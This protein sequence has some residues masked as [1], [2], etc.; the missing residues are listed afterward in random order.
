MNLKKLIIS[1]TACLAFIFI[2]FTANS[3]IISGSHSSA[4]VE[5]LN[6]LPQYLKASVFINLSRSEFEFMRGKKLS[7]LERMYFK[8]SQRKLRKELKTDSNLSITKYYDDANGKFKID[9]LWFVLGTLLGPIGILFAYTTHQSKNFKK[10]ALLGTAVWLVW[11]GY[12][13]LF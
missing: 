6:H 7:F 1:T 9:G 4:S 5:S 2:F 13:F 12:F 3:A 11:F 8:S 10:S